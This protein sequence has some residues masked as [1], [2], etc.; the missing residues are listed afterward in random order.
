VPRERAEAAEAP[1]ID[2]QL[3]PRPGLHTVPAAALAESEE[4]DDDDDEPAEG[5]QDEDDTS[6]PGDIEDV[7]DDDGED[8]AE[9]PEE[10]PAAAPVAG[11]EDDLLAIFRE[12]KVTIAASSAITESVVEVSASDLLREAQE[13]RALLGRR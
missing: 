6:G 8:S 2:P 13:V 11:D 3:L 10:L 4:E 9:E 12:T 1:T 7:A 5:L